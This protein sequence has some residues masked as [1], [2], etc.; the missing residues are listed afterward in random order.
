MIVIAANAIRGVRSH[1]VETGNRVDAVFHNVAQAQADIE[2]FRDG[3]QSRPIGVEIG[4]DENFHGT[5]SPMRRPTGQSIHERNR[6]SE[7][8]FEWLASSNG[9]SIL[10]SVKHCLRPRGHSD[11]QLT[12]KNVKIVQLLHNRQA[13]AANFLAA[14]G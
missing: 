8:R 6:G 7:P 1:P 2:R 9:D 11:P 13:I 3:L 10:P 12:K 5:K 14:T 4:D